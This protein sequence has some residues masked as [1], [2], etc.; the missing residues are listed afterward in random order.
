[1]GIIKKAYPVKLITGII[2]S[3]E[4]IFFAT[5][6]LLE[7]FFGPIDYVSPIMRFDFTD[8]YQK[9]MGSGLKRLFLSF[10][11]LVD[12]ARLASIKLITNKLERRLCDRAY[13]VKRPVNIDP[14]YISEAKLV[15]ATTKDYGHRIYLC[16]GIYAELTLSYKN[17]TFR[18]MDWS[19][20][21]YKR[22]DHIKI[23]NDIRAILIKQKRT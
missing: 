15:L 21:D 6:K 11:K 20:P 13:G 1:M 10:R 3:S 4:D 12:P 17:G 5:Q 8:Y 18:P 22:E 23:F 16:N 7:H 19:Y 9:D 2:I 14:G